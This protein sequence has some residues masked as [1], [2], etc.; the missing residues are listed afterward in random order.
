MKRV[1]VVDNSGAEIQQLERIIKE[2]GG[3]VCIGKAKDGY[4]AVRMNYLEDPEVIFIDV[5]MP[6][7]DGLTALRTLKSLD[8][9]VIIIAVSSRETLGTVLEAAGKLGVQRTISKPYSSED[10]LQLLQEL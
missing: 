6:G 2:T 9:D 7:M 1:L 4:E 8:R 3:F 10:V 5:N